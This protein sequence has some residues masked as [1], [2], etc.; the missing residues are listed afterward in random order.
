MT[1]NQVERV[2][3]SSQDAFDLLSKRVYA[4]ALN[5]VFLSD[6]KQYL[7]NQIV[8]S[9]YFDLSDVIKDAF[10]ASHKNFDL[11]ARFK[12]Y[13]VCGDKQVFYNFLMNFIYHCE[14]ELSITV[15]T[16]DEQKLSNSEKY[17]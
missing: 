8:E 3:N 9:E 15:I 13:K 14:G 17:A 11:R 2:K 12:N 5:Q 6:L 16:L 4:G 7:S 1:K 10:M